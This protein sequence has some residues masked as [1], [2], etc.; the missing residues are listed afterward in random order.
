M[1][2]AFGEFHSNSN[3]NY[4]DK[5]HQLFLFRFLL[6]D[7]LMYNYKVYRD[8]IYK[9]ACSQDLPTEKVWV[10]VPGIVHR[11]GASAVVYQVNMCI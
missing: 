3:D 1:T 6:S 4:W 10:A 2:D 7:G 5:W 9:W 8:V 11:R